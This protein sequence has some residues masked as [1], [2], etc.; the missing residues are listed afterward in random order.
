MRAERIA[1]LGGLRSPFC[2]SGGLLSE[3]AADDLAA[4]IVRQ[5][6]A[7]SG[8]EP[9]Q[10][11]EVIFGNVA[12]PARSANIARVIA[13][14]AGLDASVPAQTVHRNCASGMEALTAAALQI[15]AGRAGLVL[16]GGT[17]SMSQI[18]LLCSPG[19]TALF[20]RLFRARSLRQRLGAMLSFRPSMLKPIVALQQGL[21]DPVCE[22]NMGQ[23]AEVLAAEFGVTRAEQDRFA[24]LSHRRAAAARVRLAEEIVPLVPPPGY[25]AAV[26]ADDGPNPDLTAE[27]LAS[28]RPYF[29]RDGGTVTVSNSCPLTDGAV[30]L[31]LCSERRARELG[32]APLGYLRDWAV[33]ALEGR[34]MGLGPAYATARLLERSGLRLADFDVIELNE[35]FAAQVLANVRAF[36]SESFARTHLG[37]TRALGAID[38]ERL[39]PNGGAIAL[40]HPVGATGARLVLTALSELRRRGAALGLATLCVGGGQGASLALEAA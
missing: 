18:P 38:P 30:A 35:A 4:L 2:K 11:D 9:G 34:R 8:V 33:A 25:S 26:V 23:T 12:Q 10:I 15:Q 17:E 31:L 24:L 36:E 27:S 39:N 13:L 3:V 28:R 14:K 32:L 21:T 16:V 7:H 5:L 6:L 29:Q 19:M 1:I 37:R 20:L 22:L 40:G